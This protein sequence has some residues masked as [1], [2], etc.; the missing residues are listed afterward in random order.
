MHERSTLIFLL[1]WVTFVWASTFGHMLISGLEAVE[2]AS[3][4]ST[5]LVFICYSFCGILVSPSSMPNF[6]IFVYRMNPFTYLAT[7]FLSTSLARAP[8]HCAPNEFLKFAAPQKQTCSQYMQGY[9]NANGGTLL[10]PDTMGN[11]EDCQ[12]CQYS[13]TDQFLA[14]FGA[15]YS[16]RWMDFGLL[17]VYVAFNTS[18][19]IFLYWLLRVPKKKRT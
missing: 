18:M 13:E 6:W 15:Y 8:M 14:S 11:G 9:L 2:V 3:S 12:Y 17:W 7:G 4:V 19:A 16:Q 10:N 1:I 5:F